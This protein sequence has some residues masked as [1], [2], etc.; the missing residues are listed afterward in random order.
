MNYTDKDFEKCLFNPMVK[1]PIVQLYPQ[2]LEI[3]PEDYEGLPYFDV[4]LRYICLLYDSKS[5]L[6]IN[7]RELNYRKQVAAELAG[8]NPDHDEKFLQSLYGFEFEWV[9]ILIMRYLMRFIKQRQWAYICAIE[10]A[11]WENIQRIMKPV[12][13]AE[14]GKDWDELK[15]IEIKSK[16]KDEAEKD[17]RRLDML[18]RQFFNDD[19]ELEEA[20]KTVRMTPESV[21]KLK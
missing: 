6:I 7:E 15:A 13:K 3:C 9:V 10:M 21:G 16:L 8:F 2:I 12:E 18:Y 5:P 20:V 1:K 4:V 11:Y 14:K 19:E 17:L